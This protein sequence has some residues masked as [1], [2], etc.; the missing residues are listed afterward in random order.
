MLWSVGEAYKLFRTEFPDMC[1][2]KSLFYQLRP[3]HVL[4]L[5][6]L[7]HNVCVCVYHAN[8]YFLKDALAH[9][10]PDIDVT[11]IIAEVVCDISSYACMT[12]SCSTCNIES[13]F[14]RLTQQWR[15]A[16]CEEQLKASHRYEQ[17]VNCNKE[18]AYGDFDHIVSL[19]KSKISHFRQHTFIKRQQSDCFKFYKVISNTLVL[20]IDFSENYSMK[21]QDEVQAMHWINDQLTIFTCV[22]WGSSIQSFAVVSDDLR[23]DKDQVLIYLERILN[24]VEAIGDQYSEIVIFSDGAVSQFKN[25]FIVA[26]MRFLSRKILKVIRW[27]YFATSHGKGAVDGIGGKVKRIVWDAVRGKKASVSTLDEFVKCALSKEVKTKV[28]HPIFIFRPNTIF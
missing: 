9:Y 13:G 5:S 21:F 7:P 28:S 18:I 12:G 1:L 17:W 19:I 15:L 2:K 22:S 8:F 16:L 14:D 20:Q 11:S 6:K 26:A 10:V 25:K 23:H 24:E 3:P 4:L 27:E